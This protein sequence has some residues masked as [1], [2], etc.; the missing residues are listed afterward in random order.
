MSAEDSARQHRPRRHG[1][2]SPS[3]ATTLTFHANG[4]RLRVTPVRPHRRW[5]LARDEWP[6]RC[7]PVRPHRRGLAR[8][9]KRR[10]G[11]LTAVSNHQGSQDVPAGADPRGMRR[12]HRAMR[13]CCRC[14][15]GGDHR[16]DQYGPGPDCHLQ[17]NP[18]PCYCCLS[19]LHFRVFSHNGHCR[20]VLSPTLALSAVDRLLSAV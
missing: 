15:R 3:A 4:L 11:P 2:H 6:F 19:R 18:E 7:A 5:G 9:H 16:G 10:P 1:L 13:H 17:T 8:D 14:E 20:Q 12:G